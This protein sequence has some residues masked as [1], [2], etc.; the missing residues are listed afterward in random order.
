[1]IGLLYRNEW[2]FLKTAQSLD[3]VRSQ[4]I[5]IDSDNINDENNG[6]LVYTQ[7]ML[8][9]NNEL[10]DQ[11]FGINWQKDIVKLIRNVEMYQREENS[12]TTTK[13]NMWWSQEETT[14]YTYKKKWSNKLIDSSSF[15]EQVGHANPSNM[16]V[17]SITY[18]I[19][20]AT[21]WSF[22]INQSQIES[23]NWSKSLLYNDTY[24]TGIVESYKEFAHIQDNKLYIGQ[25]KKIESTNPIVW[26]IRISWEIIPI[27][28]VS[29]IAEQSWNWFRGY[30]A[31]AGK[32]ISM[33]SRWNISPEQMISDSEKTNMVMTWVFR[34]VGV[35][36]MIV[37]FGMILNI[38]STLSSVLPIFGW[39]VWAGVGIVSFWLWFWLW[40][41]VIAISWLRYRPIA[42]IV[43]I[44]VSIVTV[45]AI[46][47]YKKK[48]TKA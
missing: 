33:V 15:Q 3:E 12:K 11:E 27:D 47:L 23:M 32:M 39:I 10:S 6:K 1:M 34:L 16:L 5:S 20:E 13:E 24:L 41:L 42:A 46:K 43:M 48:N 45:I 40:I 25:W 29:I 17:D 21:V 22:D 38:V 44:V 18:T 30:Q 14:T 35:L 37:W 28:N 2:N 31:K 7:A 19:S 9:T 26:D 4:V 36:L 8:T